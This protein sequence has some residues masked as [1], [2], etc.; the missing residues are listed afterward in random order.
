MWLANDR[1]TLLARCE[2]AWVVLAIA[3][4][5]TALGPGAA[6]AAADVSWVCKPGQAD[7]IC[8]EDLT[9]T[10]YGPGGRS[11]VEKAPIPANPPVDCF[12]VYPTVSDQP[13]PNANKALDPAI[14]GDRALAGR[15]VLAAFAACSRRSTARDTMP[16]L[17]P[18]ARTPRRPRASSPTATCSRPGATTCATTTAAVASS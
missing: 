1:R 11:R 16:A 12:Y 13:A 8:L 5:V 18:G 9:T 6:P 4:A 7:N 10:V 14:E 2:E 3:G 17:S 15:A